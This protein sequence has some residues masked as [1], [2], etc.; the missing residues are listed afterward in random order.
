MKTLDPTLKYFSWCHFKGPPSGSRLKEAH[1]PFEVKEGNW[2]AS[3][4]K[5]TRLYSSSSNIGWSGS[6]V[7]GRVRYH[8]PSRRQTPPRPDSSRQQR[9][10]DVKALRPAASDRRGVL[11]GATGAGSAG[12]TK[13][14]QNMQE[15]EANEPSVLEERHDSHRPLVQTLVQTPSHTA[16]T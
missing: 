9:E 3:G 8:S 11:R 1:H 10:L 4:L 2:T 16:E 15:E 13:K 12:G 7:P 14:K 6:R 5:P